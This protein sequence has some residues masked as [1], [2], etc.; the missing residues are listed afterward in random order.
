[1][2]GKEQ[3][4]E[5]DG[6][7]RG[8]ITTRP[9]VSVWRVH[10]HYIHQYRGNYALAETVYGGI[11]SFVTHRGT[12]P[13]MRIDSD[14]QMVTYEF[15][16]SH[17]VFAMPNYGNENSKASRRPDFRHTMYWEPSAT[18]KTSL[19][20][21]T[22]DLSGKYAAVLQGVAANGQKIDVRWEFEVK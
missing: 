13:D 8:K 2:A 3:E 15:P 11:L 10:R 21:Y 4:A 16:Q 20:F 19:E 5:G 22:S 12:I 14:M 18:G 7:R 1:M 9:S 17:P 6:E